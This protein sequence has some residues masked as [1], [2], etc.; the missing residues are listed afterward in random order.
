MKDYKKKEE[1]PFRLRC[2]Q[3]FMGYNGTMGEATAPETDQCGYSYA[4]LQ[5]ITTLMHREEKG[6]S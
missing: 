5:L 6:F 1:K 2:I 4:L 3:D